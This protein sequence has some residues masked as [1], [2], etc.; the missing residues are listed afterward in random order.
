MASA[1]SPQPWPR[2]PLQQHVAPEDRTDAVGEGAEARIA[3]HRVRIPRV[4]VVGRVEQLEADVGVPS[5][6]GERLV[7]DQIGREE[8][9]IAMAVRRSEVEVARVDR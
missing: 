5:L 9:R 6:R 8:I 2:S 3:D 7:D 4:E 1:L